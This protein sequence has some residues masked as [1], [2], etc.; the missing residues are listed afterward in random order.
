MVA[1]PF[2]TLHC[3]L[4]TTVF[5]SFQE[6][7]SNVSPHCPERCLFQPWMP[8]IMR[9]FLSCLSC[10]GL[11]LGHE[12]SRQRFPKMTVCPIGRR[13]RQTCILLNGKKH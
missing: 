5:C 3:V 9:G 2:V 11:S 1:Q 8:N 4:E 13:P 6:S 12:A 10:L 7:F